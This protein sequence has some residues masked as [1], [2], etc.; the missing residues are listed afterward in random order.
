MNK[1]E[2]YKVMYNLALGIVYISEA[3][4]KIKPMTNEKDIDAL[5]KLHI[6]MNEIMHT[7]SQELQGVK[8]GCEACM[9]LRDLTGEN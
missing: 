6:S 7:L 8:C 9:Q 4:H 1:S 5:N 2:Q 3:I